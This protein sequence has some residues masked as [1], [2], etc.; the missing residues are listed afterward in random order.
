MDGAALFLLGVAGLLLAGHLAEILSRR[1]GIPEA[2][3]L[4][5]TGLIAGP[6]TGM[7]DA[8]RVAPAAPL[9]AALALV[10]L[11]FED[12]TRLTWIGLTKTS[13]R[14]LPL[15]AAGFLV[16]QLLVAAGSMLAVSLKILPEDWTWT[17]GLLLGAILGAPA[18]LVSVPALTRRGATTPATNLANLESALADGIGVLAAG[19]L[20]ND[21]IGGT[22]PGA[23]LGR[24]LGIGLG[25]GVTAGLVGVLFLK[26][27]RGVAHPYPVTL[28]V[29]LILHA[30]I[31]RMGGNPAIGILAVAAI[32]GNAPAIARG[33][34]LNESLELGEDVRGFHGQMAFV[35]K[36]L[37]FTGMGVL[38][39]PPWPPVLLGVALA[40]VLLGA[41]RLSVEVL[42]GSAIPEPDKAKLGLAMPRGLT[43]GVLA[44]LAV[45][46]GTP[47]VESLPAVVYGCVAASILLFAVV[48]S[49]TGPAV[50]TP[51][52]AWTPTWTPKPAAPATTYAA[53]APAAV[54]DPFDTSSLFGAPAPAA[55][56]AP[57]EIKPVSGIEPDFKPGDKFRW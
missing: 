16:S 1:T 31:G 52:P 26:A 34:K 53:P 21:L 35:I 13:P 23:G 51:R 48:L 12:G 45:A 50:T 54:P 44:T 25:V 55:P 56:A 18:S 39:G 2:A 43:A 33:L 20:A 19:A 3:F 42:R 6:V 9:V 4:L 47:G 29:L 24:A 5:A 10:V 41:R 57:A 30:V 37:I 40:V 17:H 49:L 28:A 22:T 8:G 38:L 15:A 11:L 27:L 36:A 46:Q 14:A 7:V 32:L